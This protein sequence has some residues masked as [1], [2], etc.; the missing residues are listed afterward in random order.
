MLGGER[1]E[2]RLKMGSLHIPALERDGGGR[3][4]QGD[5]EE[6]EFRED[7][8][9]KDSEKVREKEGRRGDL[10]LFLQRCHVSHGA[11]WIWPVG[12]HW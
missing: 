9:K 3:N 8:G 11:H 4:S 6:T 5:V 7:L 10:C 12:L 1:G 2:E